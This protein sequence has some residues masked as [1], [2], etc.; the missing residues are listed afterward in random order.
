MFNKNSSSEDEKNSASD[1][2]S[3]KNSN[4]NA[5]SIILVI[6]AIVYNLGILFV[7]KYLDFA[8][9]N[10]NKV[11]SSDIPLK[12]IAFPI[13]ISFFVFK[14]LSYIF[15]VNSGKIKHEKNPFYYALYISFFPQVMSGPITR[16][17]DFGPQIA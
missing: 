2:A 8:I 17:E 9:V 14:S 7:Y 16:Y 12:N 5:L 15:D 11:F 13:G 10:I 4:H 1:A 6:T 3:K